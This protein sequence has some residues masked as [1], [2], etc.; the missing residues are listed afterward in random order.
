[1]LHAIKALLDRLYELLGIFRVAW[2]VVLG[3][4]RFARSAVSGYFRYE[5]LDRRL[6]LVEAELRR[7]DRRR[8]RR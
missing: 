1:M 6:T 5:D 3:F 8:P 4:F 2:S 7:G